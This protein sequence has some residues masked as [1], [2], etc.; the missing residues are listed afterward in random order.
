MGGYVDLR[1]NLWTDIC[2]GLT[3]NLLRVKRVRF[4]KSNNDSYVKMSKI[5]NTL[6]NKKTAHLVQRTT[7]SRYTEKERIKSTTEGSRASGIGS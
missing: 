6:E 2:K 1:I 5:L 3:I 4:K 7:V